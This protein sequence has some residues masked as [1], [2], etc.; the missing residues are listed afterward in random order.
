MIAKY[1]GDTD[2]LYLE[3][4]DSKVAETRDLDEQTLL[5]YDADGRLVGITIEHAKNRVGGPEIELQRIEA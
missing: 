1:L 2:T 4:R 3:F 5:D